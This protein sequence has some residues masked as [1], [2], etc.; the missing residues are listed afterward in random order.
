MIGIFNVKNKINFLSAFIL[1]LAFIFS[2]IGSVSVSADTVDQI[3]SGARGAESV[4]AGGS[5]TDGTATVKRVIK[6]VVDILLFLVGSFAVIMMVIAG[7]RF[8]TANGDANTVS[9]A[10]NTIIYS[11]IGIVVAVMSWAIVNFILQAIT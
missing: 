4:E 2:T 3:R 1:T 6:T 9:Q 7:F 8:V 5:P 10:K 11:V